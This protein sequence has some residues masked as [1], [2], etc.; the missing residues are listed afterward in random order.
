MTKCDVVPKRYLN[1]YGGVYT[2]EIRDDR[3]KQQRAQKKKE[4]QILKRLS[5]AN[6]GRS[7]IQPNPNKSSEM[8]QKALYKKLF[9]SNGISN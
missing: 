5:T 8:R 4:E 2:S 6:I 7:T 1:K 3:R 9:T